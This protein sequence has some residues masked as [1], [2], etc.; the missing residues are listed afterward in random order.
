[1]ALVRLTGRDTFTRTQGI[2]TL[3]CYIAVTLLKLAEGIRELDNTITTK[4]RLTGRRII[5]AL[6]IQAVSVAVAVIVDVIRAEILRLRSPLVGITIIGTG[7]R[8]SDLQCRTALH[9]TVRITPIGSIGMLSILKKLRIP[10]ELVAI[11]ILTIVAD[12][13]ADNR[14]QTNDKHNLLASDISTVDKIGSSVDRIVLYRNDRTSRLVRKLEDR[15]RTTGI[16]YGLL[17]SCA[18]THT[19]D[20]CTLRCDYS[21]AHVEETL[22]L[23]GKTVHAGGLGREDCRI[24][25]A[26]EPAVSTCSRRAALT[27]DDVLTVTRD[28][29]TGRHGACAETVRVSLTDTGISYERAD[30]KDRTWSGSHGCARAPVSGLWDASDLV[31]T[32]NNRTVTLILALIR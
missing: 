22:G 1:M 20:A 24:K 28:E 19:R 27:T 18:D 11:I 5:S 10:I 21:T 2:I 13:T 7:D 31:A 14:D 29:I 4:S 17:T 32:G 12:L 8:L 6:L 15:E 9:M 16:S 3:A 25:T 26:T 30:I 23:A